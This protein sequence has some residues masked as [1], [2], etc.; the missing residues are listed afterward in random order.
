LDSVRAEPDEE[1]RESL[2]L[3]SRMPKPEIRLWVCWAGPQRFGPAIAPLLREM[4][5]HDQHVDVRAE[6]LAT[7]LELEPSGGAQF[8]TRV[9]RDLR[10]DQLS[11]AEAAAWQLLKLR[12]PLLKEEMT[13]AVKRWPPTDYIHKSFDVLALCFDR[14]VARIIGRIRSH[15]HDHMKWLNRAAIYLNEPDLWEAVEEGSRKL[16]DERCR[17]DCEV[18]LRYR[19]GDMN[20]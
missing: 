17:R 16:P 14:D 3:M 10:S 13:Q 20:G 4:A 18:V 15:D 1:A 7:Y 11:T 9:R 6:A 5:L 12:D 19:A 8:W 2:E